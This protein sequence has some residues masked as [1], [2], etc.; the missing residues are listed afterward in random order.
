[1]P[2]PSPARPALPP[3]EPVPE[4]RRAA[5]HQALRV[6]SGVCDGALA[7][8]DA[9]FNGADSMF[10]KELAARD[11]LTDRQAHVALRMVRKYRRQ[12]GA[13]LYSAMYGE[14]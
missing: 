6:L 1:V 4:A 14:A 2:R 5:I 9:G 7:R 12:Y 8:D 13:E 10:G 11:R 3:V